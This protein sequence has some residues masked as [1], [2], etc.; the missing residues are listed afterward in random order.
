MTND[1]FP[2]I[3]LNEW[4]ETR[5]TIQSYA[6]LTGKI[7]RAMTPFR[8]H[9]WHASLRVAAAG[10]TTTPIR[11]RAKTFELLLDFT[12]HD[13]LIS[14]SHGDRHVIPLL[15]Q[16]PKT[17]KDQTLAALQEM[18]IDEPEID[19][20]LFAETKLGSYDSAAVAKFWQALTQVDAVFKEFRNGFREESSPVQLWPHGFDLAVNW[21]SGRLIPGQDPN[22]AEYADEQMN[23]GFSTGGGGIPEPYFYVTAYPTPPGFT[24]THLLKGARWQTE[25]WTGAVLPYKVIESKGNGRE[26]LLDF[27]T[28]L[29][30]VGSSIIKS[31]YDLSNR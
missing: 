20:A 26:L 1:T 13:L 21:F 24:D 31:G 9:W 30:E 18:D 4:Q 8:K 3:P 23:F 7:R 16:S 25:G 11:S 22:D 14:T 6:N 17:F 27:L 12:K 19:H 29:H 5:D 15:G 28:K 2:P 10:L